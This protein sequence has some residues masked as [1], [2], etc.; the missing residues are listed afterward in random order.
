MNSLQVVVSQLIHL[1]ADENHRVQLSQSWQQLVL[2]SLVFDDG[3]LHALV[4][5]ELLAADRVA[6]CDRETLSCQSGVGPCN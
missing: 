5:F 2:L 1:V 3:V 4:V 6:N